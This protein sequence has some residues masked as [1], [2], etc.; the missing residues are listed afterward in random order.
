MQSSLMERFSKGTNNSMPEYSYRNKPLNYLVVN[1]ILNDIKHVWV[2]SETDQERKTK[3]LTTAGYIYVTY[4]YS[5]RGY[6]GL[7]VDSKRLMDGIHMGK[8][9]SRDP[10]V[11]AEVM[12]RFKGKDGDKMNLLL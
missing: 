10:H 3:M 5:L 2:G 9:Y 7:W 4:D 12:G 8:H 1:Y 6:E 11:L